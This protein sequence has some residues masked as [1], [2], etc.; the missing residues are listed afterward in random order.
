MVDRVHGKCHEAGIERL[1][2]HMRRYLDS[3]LSTILHNI[4]MSRELALI[5]FFSFWSNAF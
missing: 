3:S 5:N 1:D 2:R 4:S